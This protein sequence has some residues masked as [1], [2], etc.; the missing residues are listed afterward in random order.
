MSL[1]DLFDRL[2][3]EELLRRISSSELAEEALAMAL[4]E[5][6]RRGLAVPVKLPATPSSHVTDSESTELAVLERE[7][8]PDEAE[9]LACGLQSAGIPYTYSDIRRVQ[10]DY[11]RAVVVSVSILVPL[12]LLTDAQE[13]IAAYRRGD[14]AIDEDFDPSAD[15]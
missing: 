9:S 13:A 2:T 8:P 15:V 6:D 7:L 11:R 3:D 14:L 10:Q 4:S 1:R 5:V 12:A